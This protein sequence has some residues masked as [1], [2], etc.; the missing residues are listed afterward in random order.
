MTLKSIRELAECLRRD[1]ITKT[2]A[3]KWAEELDG[4]ANSW[5]RAMAHRRAMDEF[6]RQRGG[7][8]ADQ[9]DYE[10]YAR[11]LKLGLDPRNRKK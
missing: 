11:R 2:D 8:P 7:G 9:A 3:C 6:M 10:G 5:E 4:H 1:N